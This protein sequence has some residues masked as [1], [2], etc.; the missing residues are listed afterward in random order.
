[1][2]LYVLPVAVGQSFS[3]VCTSGFAFSHNGANWPESE[4]TPMFCRVH[5][6]AAPGAKF[7]VSECVVFRKRTLGISGTVFF[8]GRMPVFMDRMPPPYLKIYEILQQCTVPIVGP[9]Q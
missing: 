7:A 1:M 3:D 2:S 6:V 8:T 9:T 4:T 5:R